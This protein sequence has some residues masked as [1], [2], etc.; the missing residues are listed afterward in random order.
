M[1]EAFANEIE[2]L[3]ESKNI[4]Y[5]DAVILWCE[6]HSYEIESVAMLIKKDPVLRAKIRSE[7]E[8]ANLLKIKR[9]S[10]LPL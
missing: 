9:G 3:C 10:R 1:N 2:V 8:S 4:P 5:M 6:K 7:A